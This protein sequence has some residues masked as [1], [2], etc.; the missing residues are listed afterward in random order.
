MISDIIQDYSQ[1]LVS[2]RKCVQCG[3]KTWSLDVTRPKQFFLRTKVEMEKTRK[4]GARVQI[5]L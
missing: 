5:Y 4:M 1:E 3:D 2:T